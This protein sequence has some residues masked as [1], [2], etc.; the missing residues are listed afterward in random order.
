MNPAF[1][2]LLKASIFGLWGLAPLYSSAEPEALAG[3][4]REIFIA[5][6][7]VCHSIDYIEMHAQFGTR[8]LWEVEVTKMRNAFK[9]PMSDD[10]ARV[11]V[12]YLT[13]VYGPQRT[14][15]S[16]SI[17]NTSVAPGRIAGG[18]PRSP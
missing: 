10:D 2:H 13:L 9:A 8:A 11:I 7:T 15:P 6:C 16:S 4:G 5:R 18:A 3:P 14:M 1:R 12:D 17:S